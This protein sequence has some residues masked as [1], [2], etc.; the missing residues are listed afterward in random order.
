MAPLDP[1]AN[2]N[3]RSSDAFEEIEPI[4][5]YFIVCE[6]A[7]TEPWYFNAIIEQRERV[8]PRSQIQLVLLRKTDEDKDASAPNKLVKLARDTIK[9][10]RVAFQ[11]SRDDRIFVIFDADIYAKKDATEYEEL[12]KRQ[13]EKIRFGVTFP[14]F[15]LF[16]LLHFPDSLEN[17]IIP[18]VD[19][20]LQNK[21]H[22]KK[23]FVSYLLTHSHGFDAKKNSTRVAQLAENVDVAIEQEKRVNQKVEDAVGRLTSN[24]GQLLESVFQEQDRRVKALENPKGIDPNEA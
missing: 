1:Y 4:R 15:E 7:N 12:V 11:S 20:I 9:G 19:A 10:E 16:L 3:R 6:G 21:R 5:R 17:E 22:G 18:N 2:W 8:C 24:V 13:D 14:S 23:R